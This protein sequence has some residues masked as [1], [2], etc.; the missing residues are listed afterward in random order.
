[1]V[2]L[3]RYYEKIVATQGIVEVWRYERLN[4]AGGGKRENESDEK[5]EYSEQNYRERQRNRRNR[6]RQLICTN[7]DSGSKFVTLTFGKVDFDITD[8]KACNKHFKLFILRLKYRYPELKYVAVIEF[9]KRGAVH[10][11]MICNLPFVK[12]KELQEIWGAGFI[13]INAI[14]K[15][16]NVG[17]YVIK[18]MCKDTEDKRLQGLKAYNCS[19]GLLEPVQLCTWRAEDSEAWREI[20]ERLEKESPSYAGTYESENAGKIEYRQYNFNRQHDNTPLT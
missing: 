12:K 11:H 13:K 4:T 20:H 9:Q 6:I 19:K 3:E 15:V 16:D 17:A 10:Y 7:F 2:L 14:D 1:M 5:G 8:V 18:Y